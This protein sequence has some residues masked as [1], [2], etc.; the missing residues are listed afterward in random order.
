MNHSLEEGTVGSGDYWGPDCRLSVGKGLRVKDRDTSGGNLRDAGEEGQ[1]RVW[2]CVSVP[3]VAW[4]TSVF[5]C[6]L[7][8]N[9]SSFQ[10]K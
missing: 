5:R 6:S 2:G 3:A 1:G 4:G 10:D 9:N 7:G 8:L